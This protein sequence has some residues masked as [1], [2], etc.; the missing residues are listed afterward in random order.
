MKIY[1]FLSFVHLIFP[2]F[3]IAYEIVFK[4]GDFVISY[5]VRSRKLCPCKYHQL[6][7]CQPGKIDDPSVNFSAERNVRTNKF[8]NDKMRFSLFYVRAHDF[9]CS[10]TGKKR[11]FHNGDL[12]RYTTVVLDTCLCRLI[13]IYL[14]RVFWIDENTLIGW[15][16]SLS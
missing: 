15:D 8:A 11:F 2:K 7:E 13:G 3:V 16:V 6:E 5:T 14:P 10:T 12:R 4:N 1:L 9:F